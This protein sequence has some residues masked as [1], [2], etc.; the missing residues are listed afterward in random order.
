M[1]Q[2]KLLSDLLVTKLFLGKESST[3]FRQ[4][5]C[6]C[7]SDHSPRAG[8]K[9]E[10]NLVIYNCFNCGIK[11][12]YE[13]NTGKF[14]KNTRNILSA[15][16]ITRE[17]LEDISNSIFFAAAPAEQPKEINLSDLKKPNFS[18]PEVALPPRS[19]HLGSDQHF[20]LQ[21]P[22]LEYLE[23][24]GIDAHENSLMYSCDEKYLR[25]V[26]IPFYRDGKIIYWQARTIDQ[27][28]RRYLNC[29]ISKE[30]IFYGYTELFKWDTSPLFITE[31]VFDAMQL[32][33]VSIIGSELNQTKLE[34]LHRSK[35]RL[36]FVIDR[37]SNG[38]HLGKIA[39]QNNWEITFV[40]V[41][42][43]DVNDSVKKFGLQ[44]TVYSLMKNISRDSTKFKSLESSLDLELGILDKKLR[45][46]KWMK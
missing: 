43:D 30:A 46:N 10:S 28:K 24:R 35:R 9:F 34:L 41:N 22:I 4:L 44:Y 18:T 40:D 1:Q 17:E 32:R 19:F 6:A 15:F 42:A 14:N 21:I 37:D 38:H 36:I 39:L 8:F 5:K 7:C 31:G 26:I 16:G 33:G 11:L 45:T 27:I 25:R 3:G 29:V 20:D 2:P 13:E 12:V 23:H